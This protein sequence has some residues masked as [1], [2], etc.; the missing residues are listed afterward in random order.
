MQGHIFTCNYCA[1]GEAAG[2]FL[3]RSPELVFLL[4]VRRFSYLF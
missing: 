1:V 2:V 3:K 4:M